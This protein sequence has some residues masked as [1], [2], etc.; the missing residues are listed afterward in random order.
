[1]KAIARVGTNKIFKAAV[2][3]AVDKGATVEEKGGLVRVKFDGETMI[4]AS[5]FRPNTWLM[6][7]NVKFYA[8]PPM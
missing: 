6:R 3:S 8:V 4:E 1:M 7:Y 5:K 2:A